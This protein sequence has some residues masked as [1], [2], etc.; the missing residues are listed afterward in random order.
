[1]GSSALQKE[2]KTLER[3]LPQLWW[4]LVPSKTPYSLIEQDWDS[5]LTIAWLGLGALS[6]GRGRQRHCHGWDADLWRI[7]CLYILVRDLELK[8][9][10]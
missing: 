8:G 9:L 10:Q 7:L 3:E 1:M 5:P 2:I 6:R 4:D